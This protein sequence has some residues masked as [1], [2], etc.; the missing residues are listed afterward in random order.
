MKSFLGVC[1]GQG[2]CV[3][4]NEVL[5][6]ITVYLIMFNSIYKFYHKPISFCIYSLPSFLQF[7]VFY[8]EEV[9]EKF[10]FG[11]KVIGE[12]RSAKAKYDIP[13]KTKVECK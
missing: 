3:V 1:F 5:N 10:K 7:D 9:E 11:Q 8:D 13:N 6:E 2:Q 4:G 12:I